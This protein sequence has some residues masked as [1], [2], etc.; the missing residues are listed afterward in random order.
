VNPFLFVVGAARSGTTLL[1]RI[2][3]AHP[4]IAM[5]P[6]MHWIGGY[7]RRRGVRRPDDPVMRGLVLGLAD[8]S[9]LARFG[10]GRS[11][12]ERLT[13]DAGHLRYA[14]LLAGLL[15]LYREREGKPR[16]GSKTAPWVRR[17]GAL[18]E[19]WPEARFVHLIRDGRDVCLSIMNWASAAR[20]VG[21]H[22]AWREE[23]V[24]TTALWW[25]RKVV[26]GREGGTSLAPGLYR[27]LRYESLV[28]DTAEECASLCGFLGIGFD[29]AMLRFAERGTSG[30][31]ELD[32]AHPW[33][34]VTAGLRDW[35]T[36][37]AP[38]DV[39]LFEAAAGDLLAELGYARAYPRPRREALRR[40]AKARESLGETAPVVTTGG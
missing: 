31:A 5:A 2:V 1:G 21:R 4:Q 39:E 30:D 27:E 17:I 38:A 26:Q 40:A 15:E 3:D 9:R 8:D 18:H 13:A 23:P 11:D 24:L 29:R 10:L 34:P 14:D 12:L 28:A 22:P 35:R 36:Q 7:F 6:S 37:M 19:F 33:L 20:S 25:E 16:V 32:R